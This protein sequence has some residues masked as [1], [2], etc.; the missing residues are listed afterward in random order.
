MLFLRGG[1]T[2]NGFR[3]SRKRLDP[4]KPASPRLASAPPWRAGKIPCRPKNSERNIRHENSRNDIHNNPIRGSLPGT[5]VHH[6]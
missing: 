2:R 4:T 1:F 3:V 6:S 5:P